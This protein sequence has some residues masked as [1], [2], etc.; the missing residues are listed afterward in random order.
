[1]HATF[2]SSCFTRNVATT[3]M[4]LPALF[5]AGLWL[6]SFLHL[7]RL[8]RNGLSE[9]DQVPYMASDGRCGKSSFL[10][11]SAKVWCFVGWFC[12]DGFEAKKGGQS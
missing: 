8:I 11:G 2:R 5:V 7:M 12:W 9:E 10:E 6:N 3:K 1:M 4:S